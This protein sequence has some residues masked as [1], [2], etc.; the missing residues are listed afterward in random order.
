MKCIWLLIL[1]FIANVCFAQTEDELE[2]LAE[3]GIEIEDATQEIQERINLN[4]V[5]GK[6]LENLHFLSEH[7]IQGILNYRNL[8]GPFIDKYELL[9][10]PG[11]SNESIRKL[12]PLIML[13]A[14]ISAS[15]I[16]RGNHQLLL[17][18]YQVL[19][20]S[21][22]YSSGKYLGS[23]QQF[24]FRHTYRYKNIFN[25]NITA[26]KDA[27]E[28]WFGKKQKVFDFYSAHLAFKPNKIYEE[29]II[30]DFTMRTG[31]GLIQWQGSSLGRGVGLA[32]IK[33]QSNVFTPYRSVN[34]YEFYRG[35]ASTFRISKFFFGNFISLKPLSVTLTG[36]SATGIYKAGL[37]RT[38][39]ELQKKNNSSQ[40]ST[41]IYAKI[42][43]KK[44][45]AGITAITHFYRHP[46]IKGK[47]VYEYFDFERRRSVNLSIDYNYTVN[48]FH[49]FGEAAM[50]QS[51][52]VA[53][54][55]GVLVSVAKNADL[56]FVYRRAVPGFYAQFGKSFMSS[57]EPGNEK[58]FFSAA[59][60]KFRHLV[61]DIHADFQQYPWL[62]YQVNRPSSENTFHFTAL[63][64]P[65]KK[66]EITARLR[67][68]RRSKN[69][70]T[71]LPLQPV[72][73]NQFLGFR[74]HFS[75]K[76]DEEIT[77][78]TR[79]ETVKAGKG[80]GFL[81]FGDVLFKPLLKPFGGNMRI[82]WFE[83]TSYETRLYAFE[84][85]VYMYNSIPVFSGT[86]THFYININTSL[87]KDVHLYLKYSTTLTANLYA[88]EGVRKSSLRF[89]IIV[90]L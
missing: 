48:N 9:A 56:L 71:N 8:F 39:T 5:N 86:G 3:K 17:R 68:I 43:L 83:T 70:E 24:L 12:I 37:F 49:V 59:S 20:K 42:N 14:D 58:G 41:G 60:F 87:K 30:G 44:G 27:G 50:D 54:I 11:L 55:S 18:V 80:T 46:F 29:V 53:L 28:Q 10:V 81:W 40:I 67:I 31:Q 75:K 62:R 84:N 52:H 51:Y 15:D 36:D 45:N 22:E 6:E 35:L 33:R 66:T 77:L 47:N 7:E 32:A 16:R 23:R 61:V 76:I 73:E 85:D 57:G 64:K 38:N 4:K 34:E 26:E 13:S 25:Y 21:A 72:E 2:L 88:N 63:Y 82:M 79:A 19:E 89:Q 69:A 78:R 74:F 65:N 1:F 90:N